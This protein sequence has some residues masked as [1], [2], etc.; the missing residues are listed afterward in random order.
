MKISFHYFCACLFAF[1]LVTRTEAQKKK[2]DDKLTF[3]ITPI[4][5]YDPTY[6]V[7]LGV[8]LFTEKPRKFKTSLQFIYTFRKV[9]RIEPGF[10]YK[11]GPIYS[12]EGNYEFSNGFEPFY[13]INNNNSVRDK[14]DVFGYFF[15]TRTGFKR[16][17]SKVSST[18]LYL[19]AVTWSPEHKR[20]EDET[21]KALIPQQ[22]YAGIGVANVYDR[23]ERKP[24]ISS[25]WSLEHKLEYLQYQTV[26]IRS[27]IG[28]RYF[29]PLVKKV[30]F[31][32]QTIGGLSTGVG[33]FFQNYFLGGTDRLRGYLKNRYVGAQFFLQQTEFRFPLIIQNVS[34]VVFADAGEV[35]NSG[36][37][38]FLKYTYGG[39]VRYAL[40]PDHIEVLRIDVGFAPDQWG[41][42]FDFGQAF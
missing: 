20:N 17:H 14:R 24:G 39:G 25:G 41:V 40:P 32:F 2:P 18:M 7:F 16:Q 28:L 21:L 38:P 31:A 3:S 9:Y 35:F 5:G 4:A 42:F 23:V 30:G 8:G 36:E 19:P 10:V 26:A 11:L 33:N 34:G 22:T 37:V 27:S 15:S 12:I 13:G 1:L 29:L 6:S